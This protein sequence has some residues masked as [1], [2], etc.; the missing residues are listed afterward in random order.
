[1][2]LHELHDRITGQ[3]Q[4]RVGAGRVKLGQPFAQQCQQ[5]ADPQRQ[6]VPGHQAGD[7]EVVVLHLAQVGEALGLIDDQVQAHGGH[8]VGDLRAMPVHF[9]P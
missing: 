9:L 6:P 1:M 7:V 8:M 4:A 2:Q 5:Q 3:D